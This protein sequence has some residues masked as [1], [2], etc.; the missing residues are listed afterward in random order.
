MC[1]VYCTTYSCTF[2]LDLDLSKLKL[3]NYYFVSHLI[4]QV[5]LHPHTHIC[6]LNLPDTLA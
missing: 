4:R 2:A 5:D 1:K 3:S 6:V